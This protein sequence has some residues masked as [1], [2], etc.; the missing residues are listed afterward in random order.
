[1]PNNK[2]TLAIFLL[3]GLLSTQAGCSVLSDFKTPRFTCG[4]PNGVGCKPVSKVYQLSADGTL[5]NKPASAAGG[6]AMVQASAAEPVAT[7]APGNPIL[8][9]PRH[10]RVWVDRWED[11][12]GDLHD[13]TYLYL[14]LD[15]G[16]WLLR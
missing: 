10:I 11:P 3:L 6:T 1:M 15:S 14:R 2:K 7:V 5:G 12:Q 16:Q 9:R 4:L 13:E 8:T